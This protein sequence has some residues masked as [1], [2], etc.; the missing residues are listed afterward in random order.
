MKFF[1]KFYLFLKKEERKVVSFFS[2][3]LKILSSLCFTIILPIIIFGIFIF[4]KPREVVKINNMLIHEIEQID[5][6]K[7]FQFSKA[8]ISID[9]YFNIVYSIYDL[10]IESVDNIFQVKLPFITIKIDMINALFGKIKIND[11]MLSHLILSLDEI[12]LTKESLENSTIV[13]TN[14]ILTVIL[15]A[16]YSY[17]LPIEEIVLEKSIIKVDNENEIYLNYLSLNL[18]EYYRIK[19]D[20][21]ILLSFKTNKD[22]KPIIVES[23]CNF[24]LMKN[25]NCDFKILDANSKDLVRLSKKYNLFYKYISNVDINFSLLGNAYIKDYVNIETLN[26]TIVSEIGNFNFKDFFN[27]KIEYKNLK[28]KGEVLNNFKAIKI[29][30]IKT[31]IFD[32][33]LNNYFDFYLIFN[34]FK[35]KNNK[36][37][38]FISIG[39]KVSVN[40]LDLFWPVFL[41]QLDIRKWVVEHIHD[42]YINNGFVNMDFEEIKT[43][44]YELIKLNSEVNIEGAKIDYADFL[45]SFDKINAKL[46]FT[47]TNMNFEISNAKLDNTTISQAHIYSDFT[48]NIVDLNISAKTEGDVYELFYFAKNDNRDKTKAILLNYLNGKQKS[49]V[50]VVVP[51]IDNLDFKD[52]IIEANGYIINNNSYL[53]DNNSKILFNLNKAELSNYFDV[54]LNLKNSEIYLPFINLKKEKNISQDLNF[55]VEL[56]D[57]F[58][59][60]NNF[61]NKSDDD[62]IKIIGNGIIDFELGCLSDLVLDEV[63]FNNTKFDLNYQLSQKQEILFSID[64]DNLILNSDLQSEFNNFKS[65]FIYK[66]IFENEKSSIQAVD[67]ELNIKNIQFKESILENNVLIFNKDSKNSK[68]QLKSFY[69]DTNFLSLVIDFLQ[70]KNN[71]L[72]SI[73]NLGSFLKNLNITDKLLNGDLKIIMTL[74]QDLSMIGNIQLLNKFKILTNEDYTENIAIKELSQYNKEATKKLKNSIIK[75]NGI[76][77]NRLE[78]EFFFHNGILK[79]KNAIADGNFLGYDITAKGK[80]NILTGKID[81][82]GLIIPGGNINRLFILDKI[83]VINEVLFSGKNGGVFAMKYSFNKVDYANPYKLNVNFTSI[84]T[85]GFTRNIFEKF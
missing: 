52:V 69:N 23:K 85:P 59:A 81:I 25:I 14:D 75:E 55:Q 53:F 26:F 47:E 45:P 44:N 24:G 32:S 35:E 37:N 72:F 51:L 3:C 63:S 66:E 20:M 28:I 4:I 68:L 29:D 36:I 79:I 64:A 34:K 77:F 1:K 33:Y 70:V 18:K 21:N 83:P 19:K 57:T 2:I 54:K 31:Q 60:L 48:K 10:E 9:T 82:E 22:S 80:I 65:N 40:K 5:K 61:K 12:D 67:I 56:H 27:N 71:V 43:N 30:E 74:N 46:N 13:D 6:I 50:K 76:V 39:D 16:V 38:L 62:F 15:D 73:N 8:T 49:K 58:I 7:T 78:S 41:N 11:L 84:L 17:N 42:G